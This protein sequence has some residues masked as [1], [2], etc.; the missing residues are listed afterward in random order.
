MSFDWS[1]FSQKIKIKAP[2]ADLYKGWATRKGIE[3]W[4]L[5]TGEFSHSDGTVLGDDEFITV[6]DTYR[7]H[8]HGYP[9]SVVE[10][11]E[12][13]E[14]NSKDHLKFVFGEAGI[15]SVDLNDLGDGVTEMTITQT[16][17]PTDENGK[18]NYHVGCSSGWTFYRCNMKSIF[19]GGID[20]RNKGNDNDMNDYA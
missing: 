16:N 17:I 10:R 1:Q 6:G 11:G 2:V 14:A 18:Q 4:F 7:W 19:E 12:I 8:W 13:L 9:D 20:I 5:R 3:S 15:V